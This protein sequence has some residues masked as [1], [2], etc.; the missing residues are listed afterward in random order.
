MKKNIKLT[1][2]KKF[3][4]IEKNIILWNYKKIKLQIYNNN[5]NIIYLKF[6]NFYM[7]IYY[8]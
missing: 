6:Y 8:Y 3:N 5:N 1:H 4:L 7:Y 2:I